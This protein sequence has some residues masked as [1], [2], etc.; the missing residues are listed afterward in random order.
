MGEK[1]VAK[2]N[3]QAISPFRVGRGNGA[4]GGRSVDDVIVNQ[5]RHVNELDR[6][7]EANVIFAKFA[8]GSAD[9]S[10]EGGADSFAVGL[11]DI[12]HVWLHAGVEGA[13]LLENEGF[14]LVEVWADEFEGELSGGRFGLYHSEKGACDNFHKVRQSATGMIEK[15]VETLE[16]D[17]K[18]PRA[19]RHPRFSNGRGEGS[20]LSEIA[21]FQAQ[22]G[23]VFP[24]S[25]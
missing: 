3:G 11:A 14:D 23:S 6:D 7:A 12:L 10:G 18:Y 13:N 24:L 15:E 21:G 1:G 4:S 17:E 8:G 25:R 2:K 5:G 16:W 22:L 9:E 19:S 20:S